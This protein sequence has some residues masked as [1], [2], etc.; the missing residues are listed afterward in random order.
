[1]RIVVHVARMGDLRIDFFFCFM[2]LSVAVLY[3][4]EW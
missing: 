2:T 3:N 1:M 4:D